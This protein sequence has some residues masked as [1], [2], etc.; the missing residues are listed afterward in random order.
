[1]KKFITCIYL[2]TLALTSC[3]TTK[4]N[5]TSLL[6]DDTLFFITPT[7]DPTY[8]SADS[9]VGTDCGI[10]YLYLTKGGNV[11]YSPLC[12]GMDTL[13][14]YMGNYNVSGAG[15]VCTFQSEYSY[16]LA[17]EY[18]EEVVTHEDP[19]SGKIIETKQQPFILKKTNCT[20][21]P[22]YILDYDVEYKTSLKIENDKSYYC[23]EISKIKALEEFHCSFNQEKI[24]TS[25]NNKI[26]YDILNRIILY[27]SEHNLMSISNRDETDSLINLSFKEKSNETSY[28]NISIPKKKTNY[29]FGD[30]NSD[31]KDDIVASI[32]ADGGGSASWFE[33]ITFIFEDGQYVLK[34]MTNSF[35]IA[36]CNDG[37]HDGQ[38]YPK[39]INNGVIYGKSICYTDK[40]PHC[41]P[42]IENESKVIY[43]DGKLVKK[44]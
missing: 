16:S 15:I 6:T 44:E 24:E 11:L 29:I 39:E 4:I 5:N 2:I 40:D 37:S 22:Y 13:T 38:F 30:L 1:M 28:S 42:S 20:N 23:N 9:V 33:Y 12:L 21:F 7:T 17:P 19:N 3:K 26:E 36:I 18:S 43:K 25:V 27:Y 14:Y 32:Y 34:S 35:N 10:G 41:C 31:G 8:C